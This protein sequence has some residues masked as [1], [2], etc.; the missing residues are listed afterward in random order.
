MLLPL[1]VAASVCKC[2]YV[3]V[4]DLLIKMMSR[5]KSGAQ[6]PVL[7]QATSTRAGKSIQAPNIRLP[8]ATVHSSSHKLL[9]IDIDITLTVVGTPYLCRFTLHNVNVPMSLHKLLNKAPC[10]HSINRQLLPQHH[11]Q[12]M[13]FNV[14]S[15]NI[16]VL[17]WVGYL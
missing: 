1:H 4:P 11:Q 14:Y 3:S 10:M 6:L 8:Q 5:W 13:A 2:V 9:I 16:S 15:T 7:H 12:I 17:R